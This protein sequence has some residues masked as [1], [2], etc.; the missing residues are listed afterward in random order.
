METQAEYKVPSDS[1][2]P[3]HAYVVMLHLASQG[4]TTFV[5]MREVLCR[6]TAGSYY[7]V[8]LDY[9]VK[10]IEQLEEEWGEGHPAR[11]RLSFSIRMVAR[12]NGC[13]RELTGDSTVQPTLQQIAK[14]TASVAGL[15]QMG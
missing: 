6:E 7:I 1:N 13:A 8:I 9:I 3:M 10:K 4:Y 2:M 5:E 14:L 11:S 12:G 15:R